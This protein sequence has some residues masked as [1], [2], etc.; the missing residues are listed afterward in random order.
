MSAA[1]E[2]ETDSFHKEP[3]ILEQKAY[4]DIW[5]R[6]LDSY[7]QWLYEALVIF[8][9]LLTENGSLYLHLDWRL[10]HYA[11][12]ALDE[13]FGYDNFMCQI[14]WKRSSIRKARSDKW[15]SV[16]DVILVATKTQEYT[17]NTVYLPYSEEYKKR[18]N[19]KDEHGYFYWIDIGTY[20]Q[21]RMDK[22]QAQGRVRIP[23]T[24]KLT[25]ES[26]TTYTRAREF[27]RITCGPT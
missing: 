24:Q 7:L 1:T 14:I 25:Q 13:V 8:K 22:L 5:G 3:S 10:C 9:E 4:R 12:A 17:F 27:S 19:Q 18:F 26:S 2:S 15:L 11:K 6:G 23:I 21:E 20:S 16:D